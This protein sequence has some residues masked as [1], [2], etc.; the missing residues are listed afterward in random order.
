MKHSETSCECSAMA[1]PLSLRCVVLPVDGLATIKVA[2]LATACD[3][4]TMT[5]V[6]LEVEET[7]LR[8]TFDER[9]RRRAVHR[10]NAGVCSPT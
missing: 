7:K 3:G 6:E 8:P 4:N 1:G 9:S 10:S 2:A 5:G